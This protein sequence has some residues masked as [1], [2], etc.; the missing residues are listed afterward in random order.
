[1]D[2]LHTDICI[3]GAG[4]IGLSLALELHARNLS[5]TVVEAGEPLHEASWAAAGMLAAQDPHNPAELRALSER[6]ASMYPHFLKRLYA[7]GGVVVPFQT[8]RT[9][10]STRLAAAANDAPLAIATKC[11]LSESTGASAVPPGF[12]LLDEHSIDPRQL[13]SSLLAAVVATPIRMFTKSP[14]VAISST[15]GTVR[16]TTTSQIM[17]AGHFIDCT[18][19][20]AGDPEYSVVPIK[21]QM[22]AVALPPALLLEIAVRT[23]S[24]YIVPRTT[25]PMAGRTI[26]GATVEDVG[27]DKT[28]H[29]SQIEDLRQ[30]AIALL[31]ELAR[32]QVVDSWAGLRPATSDRLPIL[33]AHPTRPNHW[34]A[35]GHYRN[36]ILLAPATARVM[37]QLLLGEVPCV[38]LNLFAPSRVSLRNPVTS[39][40]AL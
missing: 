2:M 18:G 38:P 32:A 39:A 30:R 5:V 9:L 40:L 13:A 11:P 25:G 21:G 4:V 3:A 8:S 17:E 6:S 33:G 7:L 36:G 35:T 15:S 10:Q 24:I 27:F 22:L 16:I 12:D 14:V 23:A 19:A 29:P 31:P 26:I 37:A 34:I 28:V 1:M 20:W